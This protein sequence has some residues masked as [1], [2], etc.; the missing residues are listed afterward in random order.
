MCAGQSVVEGRQAK[1]LVIETLDESKSYCLPSVVEC[2]CIPDNK[3][4]IA[5]PLIARAHSHLRH[6]ADKIPELEENV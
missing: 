4:K 5:T 3:S 1:C 6:I 2:N